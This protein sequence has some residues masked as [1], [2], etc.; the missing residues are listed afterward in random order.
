MTNCRIAM[1]CGGM[2]YD[3]ETVPIRDTFAFGP[4]C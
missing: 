2:L 4:E 3:V 1:H